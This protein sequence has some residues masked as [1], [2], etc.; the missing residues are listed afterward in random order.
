M[1]KKKFIS[2]LFLLICVGTQLTAFTWRSEKTFQPEGSLV[3]IELTK[4]I[5]SYRQPWLTDNQ[6]GNKNGLVIG[7]NQIL[8][9]ADGLNSSATFRIRKGGESRRYQAQLRSI[10]FQANLALLD[11]EDP[12]FWLHMKPV[13]LADETPQN[14]N[15]QIYR[16]RSGRIEER[17]AEIVRL[18]IGSAKLS[19]LS[20]LVLLASS[21]INAAGWAEIVMDGDRLVG[22]TTSGSENK[23]LTILPATFITDALERG[24]CTEG[25]G[26]GFFDF[27]WMR[28]SNPALLESK[29]LDPEQNE[30][31]VVTRAKIFE[32]ASNALQDGD[33]ILEIDGFPID[34]EGKYIDPKYGRLSLEGLSTRNHAA[35]ETISMEIWRDGQLMHIEY[36]LPR[37]D[38]NHGLIP[39]RQYDVE[40]RYLIAGG[41]LF[42]PLD[43]SLMRA[44][45][46]SNSG[47]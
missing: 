47:A 33:V 10:D 6:T 12:D 24:P 35:G 25:P 14:G 46:K 39:N 44:L 22:L 15:L 16:W 11:V 7:P 37:A 5:H 29:G 2:S 17:A 23:Q 19:D 18:H 8:T 20:H 26:H 40:P 42:Q 9:T 43:G 32:D 45:N 21:E 38:F 34:K 13:K 4:K 3:E 31:V 27:Y 41:L 1:T 30:G 36:P 28:A